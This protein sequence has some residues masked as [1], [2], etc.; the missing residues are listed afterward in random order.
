[1]AGQLKEV[2]SRIKSV[3]STQQITKAMKMVSAAKLRRAQDRIVQM[4]PYSQKLSE[5]L[6]NIV[7]A[8]EGDVTID[9][10]A[11]REVQNALVVVM[12]SNRG[13]CG[14]FNTNVNKAALNHIRTQY[15][16][17]NPKNVSVMCIGKKSVQFFRKH[18]YNVIDKHVELLANLNFDD[19]AKVAECIMVRYVFKIYDSVEII[20]SKFK[21]DSPH[22]LT[23]TN[24]YP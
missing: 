8:A 19:V 10:S 14:A 16:S 1:M 24:I 12:T 6:S 13:L 17:L 22:D 4:R 7:T 11:A 5:I 9:L 23:S 3:I 21:I 20:F 18:S 2:R 15:A